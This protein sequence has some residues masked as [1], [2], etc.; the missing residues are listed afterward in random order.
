M[1]KY[2]KKHYIYHMKRNPGSLRKAIRKKMDRVPLW[3]EFT[4]FLALILLL[5]TALLSVCIYSMEQKRT[6][7]ARVTATRQILDLKM[8]ILE[9][10]LDSLSSFAILPVYDSGMYSALLST[11]QLSAK[12]VED[13]RSTVRTCYYSRSD[14]LS[15]NIYLLNHDLAVG[16]KLGQNVIKVYEA[17]DIAS[18]KTYKD[19][20]SGTRNYTIYPSGNPK[21]LFHFVH[22]IIR[23]N[24]KKTVAIT[25]FETDLTSIAYLSSRS[26][27]PDEVLLLFNSGGELLY[28]N[29]PD[30]LGDVLSDCTPAENMR[31]FF[32]ESTESEKGY[33]DI[34]G[35]SYLLNTVKSSDG[36]IILSSLVPL[37]DVLSRLKQT[38]LYAVL[39]SLVFLI[40]AIAAAYILIRYLS[41]PL[42]ALVNIQEDFGDGKVSTVDLGRSRES[43]ELSRSFNEMTRRIDALVKE[44]Y[45]AELNEKNARLASLEAQVNPHFLYNTLQAIGSEALLNDQTGIYRMLICLASNLRYSIKAPNVVTLKDELGY[46]DNYILL[47]KIRMGDRLDITRNTDEDTLAFH[48]PKLCIQTLIENSIIHGMGEDRSSIHIDLGTS[49]KDGKAVIKVSDDGIGIEP[50]ELTRIRQSFHSGILFEPDRSIGLANLFNRIRLLYGDDADMEISSRTGAASYTSVTLV[51]PDTQKV[52]T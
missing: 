8:T 7:E 46:V 42:T 20:V 12:T 43:A 14:L 2:P 49:L 11:G 52:G 51:L 1:D 39:I 32:P 28:T 44:N 36:S 40:P 10:Y 31:R 24:D 3:A 45:A 27:S 41:A 6:I 33:L 34:N 37:Q 15:Y 38:R 50:E 35:V 22:T 18:S 16:T 26:L 23:I 29:A 47:Q 13:I 4:L 19:C 17:K 5:L 21:A 30:G 9:A 25:D 48:V